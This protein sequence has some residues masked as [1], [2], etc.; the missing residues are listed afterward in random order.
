LKDI[1]D[2]YLVILKSDYKKVKRL[3]L[4]GERLENW[5]VNSEK[6]EPISNYLLDKII[7][8]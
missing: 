4:I 2:D 3:A 6:D 1:N 7:N 5:W 8:Q